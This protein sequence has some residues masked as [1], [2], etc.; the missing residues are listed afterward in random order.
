[1]TKYLVWQFDD[2]IEDAKEISADYPSEAASSFVE[3]MEGEDQP[4]PYAS[5]D[6]D[7]TVLVCLKDVDEEPVEYEVSASIT[8]VAR[9]A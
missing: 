8:Y 6:D 1:M 7:V 5:G 3:D 2:T 4:D 9:K